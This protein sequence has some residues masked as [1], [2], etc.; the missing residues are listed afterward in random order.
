MENIAMIK[1][2]SGGNRQAS[3]IGKFTCEVDREI[4]E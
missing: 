3:K 2:R 4:A 1:H